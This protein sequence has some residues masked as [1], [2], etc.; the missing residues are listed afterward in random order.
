MEA[1]VLQSRLMEQVVL[2]AA[3]EAKDP[4]ELVEIAVRDYLRELQRK[5]IEAEVRAFESMHAEL[6]KT[7][8][9]KH[10]AIHHGQLVDF[11]E[12]FESLH[13]RVRQRYGDEAVLMR[14]VQAQAK[15]ELVFRSPTLEADRI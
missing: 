10:V 1:I 11:D 13:R 3:Q 5:K 9:G 7:H 12:Y 14:Q 2:V 15:F 4:D 8:L 6:I